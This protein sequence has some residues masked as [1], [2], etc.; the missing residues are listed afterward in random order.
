M[1]LFGAA[2]AAGAGACSPA[3]PVTGEDSIDAAATD[4]PAREFA[5]RRY[6]RHL[7]FFAMEGDSAFIVPW[8]FL[9]RTTPGAVERET[10]VWLARNGEWEAFFQAEWQTPPTRAPWRVLPHEGVR[11]VVGSGDALDGLVYREGGREL[12]V[13]LGNTRAEWSSQAGEAIRVQEASVVLGDRTSRG[14]LLDIALAQRTS[15]PPFGDWIFLLSGDSLQIFLNGPPLSEAPDTV[16]QGWGKV[17]S[18]DL[19]WPE[20]VVTATESR[21]FERARRNVP[22]AWEL[23]SDGGD[24]SGILEVGSAHLEAGEGPG[25]LLPVSALFE[26]SGSFQIGEAAYL[27][28]GLFRHRQP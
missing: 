6:E 16:F 26:V 12:E 25:P 7:V 4:A 9:A 8:S 2:L 17:A 1:L 21:A 3:P 24:V 22:V 10:R 14:E 18:E 20:I 23:G 28:R 5:G 19:D 11:L 15:D 27:V 13:L